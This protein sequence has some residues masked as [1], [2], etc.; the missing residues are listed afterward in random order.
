MWLQHLRLPSVSF[1]NGRV[2]CEILLDTQKQVSQFKLFTNQDLDAAAISR[3]KEKLEWVSCEI[4]EHF[5]ERYNLSSFLML[6]D[7]FH[8]SHFGPEAVGLARMFPVILIE[9]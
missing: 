1:E 9:G 8:S 6:T 3:P 2:V 4:F 5:W 7:L